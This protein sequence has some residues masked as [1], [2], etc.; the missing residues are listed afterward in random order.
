MPQPDDANSNPDPFADGEGRP[1]RRGAQMRGGLSHL[2]SV[3]TSRH[4]SAAVQAERC[5]RIDRLV[6]G[7]REMMIIS[8]ADLWAM[9]AASPMNDIQ[10]GQLYERVMAIPGPRCER[11][12]YDLRG[13]PE[14]GRCPECGAIY[15]HS[16]RPMSWQ[17]FAAIIADVIHAPVDCVERHTWILSY[18]DKPVPANA[19]VV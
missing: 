5:R 14:R 8:Q 11:C 2:S 19:D 15:L 7:L 1:P 17:P 9:A 4:A 13:L 6:C 12:K 18:P 3:N 10:V 16:H